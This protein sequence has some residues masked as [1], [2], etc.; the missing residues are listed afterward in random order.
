MRIIPVMD[1]MNGA[2]VRG[3]G[4]RRDQYRPII[5]QIAADARP[6]TAANAFLGRGFRD[7]YVADLDAIAGNEP[8]WDTYRQLLECGIDLWIDAGL[9]CDKLARRLA[10]FRSDD[11]KL[12]RVIVGLESI[13]R[14][15]PF[16]DLLQAIGS[17]RFVFSLDLRGGKPITR[18]SRWRERSA[19]QIA[20]EVLTFGVRSMIVLDLA[21]VGEAQG[22][23][24]ETLCREIRA[25]DPEVELIAGGGVRDQ[26][27]LD[28]L[29]QAGCNAALVASALHDGRL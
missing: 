11:R 16:D 6:L 15:E 8:A 22:V 14:I 28:S 3:I 25:S 29:A 17:E 12:H 26:R 9:S 2:V 24:T 4:G 20:G 27:D 21:Q 13:E 1:L 23:G 10:E 7:V 5:S 18:V 19:A